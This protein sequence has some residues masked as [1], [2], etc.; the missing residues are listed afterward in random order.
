LA[1]RVI[2]GGW[3]D[4]MDAEHFSIATTSHGSGVMFAREERERHVWI[5]GKSGSG[6]STF[7]FNLVMGDIY[8]GEGV[9]VTRTESG[10]PDSESKQTGLP[11]S[12]EAF[13]TVIASGGANS[14]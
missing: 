6:K 1:E 12:R 8:A 3:R 14:Q 7:L 9:A 5:V 10:Y 13:A 4:D 11:G 2:T